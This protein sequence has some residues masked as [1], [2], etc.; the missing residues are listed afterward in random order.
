MV[1]RVWC[2][3]A[4]CRPASR[5]PAWVRYRSRSRVRAKTG[6]PVAFRSA[7]VPSYVRKTKSMEAALPWLYLKGVYSGE[8]GEALKVLVGPDAKGLSASTVS[9]LKQIWAEEYR[10]WCEQ[11][12]LPKIRISSGSC[13]V[14]G[15]R[16]SSITTGK[17]R[18]ACHKYP[19]Y[20]R[21]QDIVVSAGD[22]LEP[23]FR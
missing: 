9:R 11:R 19:T 15:I 12:K 16:V 7:P 10:C 21:P 18:P 6:E 22:P 23:R 1:K 17:G 3:T 14:V 8:M 13:I 5:E 20:S 4:I 2:A